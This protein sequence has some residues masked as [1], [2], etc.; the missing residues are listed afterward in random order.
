MVR[1]EPVDV[2]V[3]AQHGAERLVLS[4]LLGEAVSLAEPGGR[5]GRGEEAPGGGGGDDGAGGG[6]DDPPEGG[7]GG[8]GAGGG[9][10][11][12]PPQPRQGASAQHPEET[13]FLNR[14]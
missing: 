10:E 1:D 8:G 12:R 14:F 11:P 6:G 2:L 4:L 5:G 9:G 3:L 13:P 7:G